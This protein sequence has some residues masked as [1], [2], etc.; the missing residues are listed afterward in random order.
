MD[1]I[2]SHLALISEVTEVGRH[3]GDIMGVASCH[4]EYLDQDFPNLCIIHIPAY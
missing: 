4:Q 2:K 3:T 1:V